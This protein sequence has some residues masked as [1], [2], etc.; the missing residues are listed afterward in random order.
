MKKYNSKLT[1]KKYDAIDGTFYLIHKKDGTL[2]AKTFNEEDTNLIA[3]I[4]LLENRINKAI[5]ELHSMIDGG[6]E[7]RGADSAISNI[8]YTLEGRA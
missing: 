6:E 8:I 3:S 5:A 1:S 7:C 4:P 2:L